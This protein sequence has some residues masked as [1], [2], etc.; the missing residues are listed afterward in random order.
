MNIEWAVGTVCC[1]HLPDLGLF[2][3]LAPRPAGSASRTLEN[4]TTKEKLEHQ[5]YILSLS[6]PPSFALS[7]F[8]SL[9]VYVWVSVC[10]CLSVSLFFTP[11]SLCISFSIV[12]LSLIV[13]V[14]LCLSLFV[15]FSLCICL[16]L[17]STKPSLPRMIRNHSPKH[18][19]LL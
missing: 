8:H 5:S 19:F 13:C 14:C 4:R 10:V 18:I 3:V 16:R 17:C 12:Y 2:P 1:T 6:L 9:F 11:C 15:C 7:L